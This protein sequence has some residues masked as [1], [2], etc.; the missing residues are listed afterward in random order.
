VLEKLAAP[1]TEQQHWHWSLP[2][3]PDRS[4]ACV[5]AGWDPA[6][7]WLHAFTA[8]PAALKLTPPIVAFLRD[9]LTDLPSTPPEQA[10][11]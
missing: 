11:A 3:W 5:V 8:T 10:V 9:A 2:K 4:P 6:N 7:V 1:G